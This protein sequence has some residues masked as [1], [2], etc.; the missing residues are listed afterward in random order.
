MEVLKS[1]DKILLMNELKDN[2]LD[3]IEDQNGNH[4]IQKAIESIPY[5]HIKFLLKGME[6]NAVK[7]SCHTYG[8]RVM[9]RILENCSESVEVLNI[10][11]E[12][13]NNIE[14]LSCDQFGNYVIQHILEHGK[15]EDIHRIIECLKVNLIP[16]CKEKFS[17]N[18][19]EKCIKCGDNKDKSE[20]ISMMLK[21]NIKSEKTYLQEMI[22]DQYANYVVQKVIDECNNEERNRIMEIVKEINPPIINSG[23]GKHIMVRLEKKKKSRK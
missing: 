4:V 5:I 22:E 21:Y 10:M 16:L 11:N 12:I 23:Y 15:S 14:M 3:L 13:M 1:E 2:V 6:G 7:Y 19:I 9:Q 17:S 18:V 20:L 8:C